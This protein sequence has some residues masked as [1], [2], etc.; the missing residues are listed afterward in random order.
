MLGK[1]NTNVVLPKA[2]NELVKQINS[3]GQV[4]IRV[5]EPVDKKNTGLVKSEIE[6]FVGNGQKDVSVVFIKNK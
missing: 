2:K 3:L 4:E 6:R 1:Y 5:I